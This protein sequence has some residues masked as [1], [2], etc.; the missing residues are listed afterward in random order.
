MYIWRVRP[1]SDGK[2]PPKGL[3]RILCRLRDPRQKQ[4]VT[5]DHDVNR[6]SNLPASTSLNHPRWRRP[7]GGIITIVTYRH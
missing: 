1:R 7:L 5:E 2:A 4:E 3:P 6:L